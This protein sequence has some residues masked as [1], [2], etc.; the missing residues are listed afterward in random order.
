MRDRRRRIPRPTR[1]FPV[2]RF[3]APAAGG[4]GRAVPRP[5][6]RQPAWPRPEPTSE[7]PCLGPRRLIPPDLDGPQKPPPPQQVDRVRPQR[8]FRLPPTPAGP[9][10]KPNTGSTTSRPPGPTTRYGSMRIAR[11]HETARPRHQRAAPDPR[12]CSSIR[13]DHAD[14]LA[15]ITE[16][17][18]HELLKHRKASS[19]N[20]APTATSSSC[21][22]PTFSTGGASRSNGGRSPSEPPLTR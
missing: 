18:L 14:K 1:D 7:I 20:G 17:T 11:G 21:P 19:V 13:F 3:G 5:G 2:T 16:N 6:C 12:P 4:P 8:R 10:G 15:P 22:E 9:A